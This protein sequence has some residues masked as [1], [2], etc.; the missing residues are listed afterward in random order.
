LKL[1]PEKS[2][3]VYLDYVFPNFSLDQSAYI[4]SN[5]ALFGGDRK[6]GITNSVRW[7]TREDAGISIGGGIVLNNR[8]KKSLVSL[9][10]SVSGVPLNQFDS[11]ILQ[12]VSFNFYLSYFSDR[13]PPLISVR[14]KMGYLSIAS[15]KGPNNV[16]F[17][18][19][20]EDRESNI[21]TWHLVIC[22]IDNKGKVQNVI[23]SFSGK[24][25]PPTVIKWGGRDSYKTL[26][27]PGLYVYRFIAAD[28]AGNVSKTKWQ[29]IEV[30][31]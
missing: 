26:L 22:D 20:A 21:K 19:Y 17:R 7:D 13:F 14:E 16:F 5:R 2:I 10:Y 30:K 29:M 9:E 12:A 1:F 24:G 8:I 23:R 6:L 3:S 4:I 11:D 18:L 27:S 15:P 25:L 28:V 31:D